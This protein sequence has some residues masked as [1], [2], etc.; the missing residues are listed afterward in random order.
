MRSWSFLLLSL[1]L[2][3]AHAV[4]TGQADRGI[5]FGG[6][7]NG[8]AMAAN[9]VRGVRCGLAW[10]TESARLT[11][12]HNDANMVAIGARMHSADEAWQIVVAFLD[13]PFS[14]ESRHLRRIEQVTAYERDKS[15]PPLPAL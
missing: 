8:E 10:N 14:G 15:L 7:G 1:V 9:R 12:A 2:P 6:S 5:V 3:A 11:R 13:T 4:A